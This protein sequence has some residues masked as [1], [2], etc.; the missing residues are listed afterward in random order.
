VQWA[1]GD[2]GCWQRS[3][4]NFVFIFL[5]IKKKTE[6]KETKKKKITGLL[7]RTLELAYSSNTMK[8]NIIL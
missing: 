3:K 4:E 6:I 2:L 8:E 7:D 1:I 5:T